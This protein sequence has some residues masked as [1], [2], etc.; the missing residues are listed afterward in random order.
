MNNS[1]KQTKTFVLP[2]NTEIKWQPIT[3][4]CGEWNAL[5]VLRNSQ[6]LLDLRAK[7]LKRTKL[8]FASAD[9][10]ANFIALLICYRLLV[11]L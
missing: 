5:V 2:I 11:T 8:L 9:V 1:K 3:A 10:T 4:L 6:I 7:P